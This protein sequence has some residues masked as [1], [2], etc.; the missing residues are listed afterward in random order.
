VAADPVCKI[1]GCGKRLKARGYCENHYRRELRHGD[2]LGGPLGGPRAKG[3]ALGWSRAAASYEGEDCLIWPFHRHK[4]TGYGRTNWNGKPAIASRA[5][6]EIAH[7]P[8]PTP[9]HQAAHSCGNAHEG[10][11]NPNHLRWAT[12][13][14][15]NADKRLHG[16]LLQGE[17]VGNSKLTEAEVREIR[18]LASSG[19]AQKSIAARFGV[20]QSLVSMIK[21]RAVW[22]HLL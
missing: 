3:V 12:V 18:R 22:A 8:P 5:I 6:C 10:C 15:N 14:E 1:D 7:G 13:K 19:E 2:P 16:T 11:V 17:S 21:R 20:N 4:A 9:R